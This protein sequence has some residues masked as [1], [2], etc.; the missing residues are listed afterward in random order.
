MSDNKALILASL[1]IVGVL[2]FNVPLL[3]LFNR[4]WQ[5]GAS[6]P[7]L[8]LYLFGAWLLLIGAI[9]WVVQVS[10]NTSEDE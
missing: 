6:L 7:L 8:Y 10:K 3:S 4:V 9:F 2:L 1:S 5:R